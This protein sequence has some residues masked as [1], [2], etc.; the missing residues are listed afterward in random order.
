MPR[1]QHP[2]PGKAVAEIARLF[3]RFA[4]ELVSMIEAKVS[5][6][7]TSVI[8]E[9][10]R[11]VARPPAVEPAEIAPR[12][13]TRRHRRQ[14]KPAVLVASKPRHRRPRKVIPNRRVEKRVPV[15]EQVAVRQAEPMPEV[16]QVPT[17]EAKTEHTL[18]PVIPSQVK[19]EHSK[20]PATRIKHAFKPKNL[21]VADEEEPRAESPTTD[22]T[23]EP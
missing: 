22:T 8:A 10:H 13:R 20:D 1:V 21:P 12:R 14:V 4:T 15:V 23:R 2:A 7:L 6:A 19:P 17:T 11:P 3:E 9:F 18:A 5:S 16:A